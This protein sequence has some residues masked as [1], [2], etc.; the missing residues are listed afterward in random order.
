MGRSWKI[1]KREINKNVELEKV[2]R[3]IT[4]AKEHV[5]VI[6]DNITFPDKL[7]KITHALPYPERLKKKTIDE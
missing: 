5:K 4:Q 2:D 3:D 7:P 1:I 6:P